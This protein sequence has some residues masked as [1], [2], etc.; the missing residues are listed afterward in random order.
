MHAAL[1]ALVFLLGCATSSGH[2]SALPSPSPLANHTTTA[3]PTRGSEDDEIRLAV[4]RYLM[5][6]NGSGEQTDV[7]F[8]CLEV[9]QGDKAHDPSLFIM[10]A[11]GGGQPSV[12]PGSSCESSTAGVFLKG[13]R[14]KGR[15]LVFRTEEMKIDGD[16]ATVSGG[17]FAAGLSA[18]GNVYTVE[19]Q[20]DGSWRVTSDK[21]VWIS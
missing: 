20:R 10:K 1:L 14:A 13:R 4:F 21:M 9:Y 3:E 12:V 15:G 19:R 11:M 17:Y 16:K 5:G 8:V 7:P 18:S 2:G 6:H